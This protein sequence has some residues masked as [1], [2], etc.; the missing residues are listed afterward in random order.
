MATPFRIHF[1]DGPPVLV[2]AETPKAAAEIIKARD[3]EAVIT[4]IKRAK[5]QANG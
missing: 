3:P 1:A 2:D 5:D 4:K